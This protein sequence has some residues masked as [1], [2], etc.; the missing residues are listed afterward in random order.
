M[1]SQRSM[2]K[3]MLTTKSKRLNEHAWAGFGKNLLKKKGGSKQKELLD[4]CRSGKREFLEYCCAHILSVPNGVLEGGLVDLQLPSKKFS[5]SE[6]LLRRLKDTQ[7]VIWDAF[8]GEDAE[9]LYSCGC[10]GYAII[11]MIERDLIE[12]CYLAA[13]PN[14]IQ[15]TGAYLLDVAITSGGTE[16]DRCVRRVLRSMC[17]PAPRG[18]RI[19]FNDFHIGKSYWRWHWAHQMSQYMKSKHINL[20]VDQ[21]LHVLD[22]GYYGDFSAKMHTSKS[23][24]SSKNTLGGLLL[25]LAQEQQAQRIVDI[26][27]II[28]NIA[29][30]SAWKAIEMQDPQT[31]KKEIEQIARGL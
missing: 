17:N 23:C 24:I 21:I 27:Q 14:G 1:L 28:D 22:E 30:L 25:F 7:K 3:P 2:V 16:M 6:F 12:P 11:R 13:M 4:A 9:M 8:N 15:K 19:V 26:E 10:W 20:S 29:Y 31:N 5:E 18:E